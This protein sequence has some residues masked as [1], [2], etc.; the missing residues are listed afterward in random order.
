MRSW[1][2]LQNDILE[3]GA[4][5]ALGAINTTKSNLHEQ[6]SCIKKCNKCLDLNN[7]VTKV[8]CVSADSFLR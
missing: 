8:S 2:V 7:Y 3:R 5:N 4:S 1:E 6:I